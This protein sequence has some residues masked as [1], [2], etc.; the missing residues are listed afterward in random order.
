MTRLALILL[1]AVAAPAAAQAPTQGKGGDGNAVAHRPPPGMCRIWIDGV[2][3]E[4]QPAPTDCPTAIRRRPSNARVIFGDEVR[5][6]TPS[7]RQTEARPADVPPADVRTNDPRLTDPR[8]TDPRLTD[9]R[10][11]DP[12]VTDPRAGDPKTNEPRTNEP[13]PAEPNTTDHAPPSTHVAHP[14]MRMPPR[15]VVKPHKP[16]GPPMGRIRIH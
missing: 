5:S 16:N 14:P 9:P 7:S 3:A 1:V 2:P 11:T 15:P 4:R 8:L 13:K 12:R 6:R 10:L